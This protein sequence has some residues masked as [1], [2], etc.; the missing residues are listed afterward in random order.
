MTVLDR[1]YQQNPQRQRHTCLSA[2]LRMRISAA[3][4]KFYEAVFTC[5]DHEDSRRAH[6]DNDRLCTSCFDSIIYST[7]PHFNYS[8][9]LSALFPYF[10]YKRC[11][12]MPLKIVL[13]RQSHAEYVRGATHNSKALQPTSLNACLPSLRPESLRTTLSTSCLN[14]FPRRLRL[15]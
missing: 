11:N 13:I 8:N 1:C 14:T 7:V 9:L 5:T 3:A 2:P 12:V 10:V 4:S 15:H 6:F